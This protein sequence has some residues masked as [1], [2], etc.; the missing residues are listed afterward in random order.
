MITPAV[1]ISGAGTLLLS[2][3]NRSGRVTDRIRQLTE[4]FKDL[5]QE[6]SPSEALA[7]EEKQMILR[8]LSLQSRRSRMIMRAMTGLYLALSLLVLTSIMIG[9]EALID[10]RLGGV[11]PVLA[12]LGALA[13]AYSAILLSIEVR[14]S[15]RATREELQFL[16]H[17][18]DH[19]ALL[20]DQF[21]QELKRP[22]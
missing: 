12:I 8:Q 22:E 10:P 7:A 1:L 17:L 21:H 4:R 20:Y 13:M 15:A 3:T 18:A 11:P 5:V 6:E 19:Y 14:L 16:V 2:T 9:A